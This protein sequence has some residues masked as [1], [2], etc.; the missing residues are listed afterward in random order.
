[1][2]P[3]DLAADAALAADLL[4]VNPRLGLLL[5]GPADPV[6]DAW[7]ARL[8]AL[9]PPDTPWRRLPADL[10]AGQIAGALDVAATLRSGRAARTAGL[11]AMALN[12]VVLIPSAERVSPGAAAALVGDD[13]DS[14]AGEARPACLVALDE[15]EEDAGASAILGEHLAIQ[16]D[17]TGCR[18]PLPPASSGDL[19]RIGAAR[20]RLAAVET[21]ADVVEAL[22]GAAVALGIASLRPPLQ[23][24]RLARAA[25]AWA[26]RARVGADEVATASRL[27]LAPRA[28]T[29]PPDTSGAV[30]TAEE[31]RTQD[32]EAGR[33]ASDDSSGGALEAIAV[34]AARSSLPPDLLAPP[35][36][37]SIAGRQDGGRGRTVSRAPRLSTRG[38]PFGARA[39]RPECAANLDLIATLQAAVPWQTV[40]GRH[41]GERLRI[42]PDDLRI[43]Q[44]RAPLRTLTIFAVDASGSAAHGRLAEA[45]GAVELLLADCYVRRD[46]VA[47]V[48]FRGTGA[49]LL[50]PPTRALAR[51]RRELAELP[52]GGGTPLAAGLDLA[53]N[54]ARAAARNGR[55]ALLALLTDG[56]ANV[57]RDGRAD[58]ARAETDSFAAA[59]AVADARLR[60]IVI[61]V[62]ARPGASASRLADAMSARYVPLPRADAAG[63]AGVLASARGPA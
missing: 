26:A 48:A 8:R 47:L 60:A 21:P 32:G 16:L 63:I 18:V 28:R 43:V 39:G 41:A 23:A 49:E 42:R 14:L 31:A 58:R 51:A 59:G 11:R 19:G 53:L 2:T 13:P 35:G 7:L 3:P 30:E 15:G 1:M 33:D 25:A 61:D 52:G 9:L 27:C 45:K 56:R 54:L 4:A 57:A 12:A 38:R 37:G 20:A 17:L 55:D 24:V 34:A 36:S 5:R 10:R 44:R 6:R 40:R 46:E 29:V 22:C 50:L 62:G